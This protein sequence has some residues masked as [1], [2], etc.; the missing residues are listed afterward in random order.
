MECREIPN[1]LSDYVD[2]ELSPDKCQQIRVHLEHCVECRNFVETFQKSLDWVHQLDRNTAPKKV[3]D[4]VLQ[5][6]RSSFPEK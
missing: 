5:A 1:I 2:G 3:C 4:A 6:F